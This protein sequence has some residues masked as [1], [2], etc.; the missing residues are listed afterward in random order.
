MVKF[1]ERLSV[2]VVAVL[3]G[4]FYALLWLIP[5]QRLALAV[6]IV[7]LGYILYFV[8]T[9]SSLRQMFWPLYLYSQIGLIGLYLVLEI[10][11]ALALVIGLAIC[12]AIAVTLWSRRAA[13]PIVFMREKP[14]RRALSLTITIALFSYLSFGHSL[15]E[16][17]P[18]PWLGWLIHPAVTVAA[19][20][21][22]FLYWSLYIS[23]RNPALIAPTALMGF[24]VL[25]ASLVARFTSFGYLAIGL[26]IAWFWYLIQLLLRFHQDKR[27]IDWARQT[28]LLIANAFLFVTLVWLIRYI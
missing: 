15:L 25:E 5:R 24:M 9:R 4:A 18:N 14:L 6:S 27:D 16:F 8:V 28:P 21:A 17:F 10:P 13:G 2:T 12:A 1:G 19:L 23:P 7:V 22:S 26:F 11:L 20:A 3:T